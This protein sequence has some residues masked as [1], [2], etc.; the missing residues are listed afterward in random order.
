MVGLVRGESPQ[1][2]RIVCGGW[3][4]RTRKWLVIIVEVGNEECWREGLDQISVGGGEGEGEGVVRVGGVDGLAGDGDE[5]EKREESWEVRDCDRVGLW[6]G[7]VAG[8]LEAVVDS[9]AWESDSM[10]AE[11]SEDGGLLRLWMR[12]WTV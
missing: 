8:E 1:R 12:R 2:R 5:K 3:R 4:E 9:V 11:V 6:L 7:W 10:S